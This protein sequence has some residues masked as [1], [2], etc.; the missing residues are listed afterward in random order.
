MFMSII[1]VAQLILMAW[2]WRMAVYWK[3]KALDN[4]KYY[5]SAIKETYELRAVKDQQI[6]HL[7]AREKN[8]VAEFQ[9]ALDTRTDMQRQVCSRVERAVKILTGEEE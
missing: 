9:K 1:V 5:D 2:F 4:Q 6:R 7:E 8:R 3:Y